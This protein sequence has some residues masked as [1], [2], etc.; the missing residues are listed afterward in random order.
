MLATLLILGYIFILYILWPF[1][2]LL[3]LRVSS[4]GTTILRGTDLLLHLAYS[5]ESLARME[6]IRNAIQLV[7]SPPPLST[8]AKYLE[9]M[10]P[11]FYHRNTQ[12]QQHHKTLRTLS[13][14]DHRRPHCPAQQQQEL[15]VTLILQTT[16]DRLPVLHETCRRWRSSPIIVVLAL[17]E[18]DLSDVVESYDCPNAHW[19]RFHWTQSDYPVNLLRNLALE[20]VSTSHVLV[21]DAD[22][23]PSVGLDESIVQNLAVLDSRQA[24]VVPAFERI[25]ECHSSDE[26]LH[27]LQNNSSFIPRTMEEL[28]TCI[29]THDCRVFQSNN[30]PDG[31]S[32]THSNEWLSE[33]RTHDRP[34]RSIE[35]FDSLRYEPYL[36]LPWCGNE[37]VPY[38]DERFHGYGKNKI[39]H[40]QHVRFLG[41]SFVVLPPQGFLVH[42]PHPDSVMKEEWNGQ[43]KLHREMDAL[44]Q[45]FLRELVDQNRGR[46]EEHLIVGPCE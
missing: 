34:L 46:L 10:Y 7:P 40:V 2:H 38:Y 26:C 31:H 45:E 9:Q 32:S 25:Q 6:A 8:R 17:D 29:Q 16:L 22:F 30:N 3:I 5:P 27:Y 20:A 42:A 1:L 12:Q 19:I 11:Q 35:C 33:P 39:Q 15:Q 28:E 13:A 18:E 24:M 23:V 21:V 36:V 4:H 41:F 44:Y 14:P 43:T 37:A